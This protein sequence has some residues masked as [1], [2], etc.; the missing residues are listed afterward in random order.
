MTSPTRNDS[1]VIAGANRVQVVQLNDGPSLTYASIYHALHGQSSASLSQSSASPPPPRKTSPAVCYVIVSASSTLWTVLTVIATALVGL[2]V[3]T[4]RWLVIDIAPVA[5]GGPVRVAAPEAATS[6]LVREAVLIGRS[7]SP[8]DDEADPTRRRQPKRRENRT[9]TRRTRSAVSPL[10]VT[11]LTRLRTTSLGIFNKCT[12]RSDVGGGV[13]G[14][15][16]YGLGENGKSTAGRYWDAGVGG[17]IGSLLMLESPECDTYVTGFDMP[18]GSFPDAWKSAVILLAAA[19]AL[20]AFTSVTAV[21]SVCVQSLFGKSIFTVSGLIQSI[22]GQYTKIAYIMRTCS[23]VSTDDRTGF[24][25][26]CHPKEWRTR[27]RTR[28]AS[29]P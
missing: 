13:G 7:P 11:S 1:D 2:A 29:T 14:V 26:E 10:N 8:L 5:S 25:M 4:P 17:V 24:E 20:L 12:E 15:G 6:V 21:V 3:L 9:A 22:A 19:S 28:K 23:T 16:G 27:G 18:D